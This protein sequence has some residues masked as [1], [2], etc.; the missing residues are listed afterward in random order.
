MSDEIRDD[1]LSSETPSDKEIVFLLH[2]VLYALQTAIDSPNKSVLIYTARKIPLFLGKF[3]FSIDRSQNPEQ[4]VE[5]LLDILRE[6]GYLEN[7]SFVK[8][9][10]R[11]Y[12]LRIE[13]CRIA[14]TGVH[15]VLKPE[16]AYCPFAIAVAAVLQELTDEDVILSDSKFI[17]EG[18]VTKMRTYRYVVV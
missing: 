5:K 15:D 4:N 17:G 3:G 10:E 9:D 1:R 16:K 11:T 13:R 6:T 2:A 7:V 12:E 8:L 18:S 14:E